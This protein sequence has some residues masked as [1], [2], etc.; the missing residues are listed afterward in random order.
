MGQ[1]LGGTGANTGP[2]RSLLR[3]ILGHESA[4]NMLQVILG[5]GSASN[6]LQVI[7]GHESASNS[8]GAESRSCAFTIAGGT[9]SRR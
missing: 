2:A 9:G 6:I 8:T 4:S 7:L 1:E 3:V 5:H